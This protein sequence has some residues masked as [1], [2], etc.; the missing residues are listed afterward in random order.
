MSQK[1]NWVMGLWKFTEVPQETLVEV[2]SQWAYDPKYL[3]LYI[4]QASKDQHAIG[5]TYDL[6]AESDTQA[7]Y[8]EYC[9]QTTD[10]LKKRFGNKFVGW[11]TAAPVTLVK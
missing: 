1:R 8:R 2:A 7:A 5:F 9:D 10:E 11:D 4:R 3:Y 6:S